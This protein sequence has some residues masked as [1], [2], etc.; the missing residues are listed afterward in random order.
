[1]ILQERLKEILSSS[2]AEV[3]SSAINGNMTFEDMGMDSLDMFNF[4]SEIDGE[5][6]VDVPD[7]VFEQL[8]TLNKL[9]KYLEAALSG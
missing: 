2:G 9:E 8:T 3:D 1:M 5:L 7:E 6:G 4:F